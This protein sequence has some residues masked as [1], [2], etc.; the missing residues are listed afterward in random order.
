MLSVRAVRDDVWAIPAPFM[1]RRPQC[2]TAAERSEL[3]NVRLCLCGRRENVSPVSARR[4]ARD[5]V[6]ASC[7][8]RTTTVQP[9][10]KALVQIT[11]RCNLHCAH[12][13]VSAT[14]EGTD[15][16]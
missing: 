9:E 15:I 14:R 7:Y 3:Q 5:G 13:F 12:C 2:R 4:V 8:F 10:R 1:V 11:E 6:A 16:P